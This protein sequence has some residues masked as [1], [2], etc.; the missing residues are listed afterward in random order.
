MEVVSKIQWFI[1]LGL[2]SLIRKMYCFKIL[3]ENMILDT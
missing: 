2:I 1:Q 3:C